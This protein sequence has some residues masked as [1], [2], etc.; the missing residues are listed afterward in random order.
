MKTIIVSLLFIVVSAYSQTPEWTTRYNF[1]SNFADVPL[2]IMT[3][4]SGNSYVI[5]VSQATATL[6]G[7]TL[8]KYNSS[9]T[10][11]WVENYFPL[12]V[13]TNQGSMANGMDID[14]QGNIYVSGEM[15]Y[16]PNPGDYDVLTLK[17]NS[18]G[19]K[20]W[21]RR[22]DGGG[23]I[24]DHG[25]DL[26]LSSDG[27]VYAS[28]FSV[29]LNNNEYV[30]AA[31][32]KMDPSD[33]SIIWANR[34][35]AGNDYNW[36]DPRRIA[37]DNNGNVYVM[38]KT[39]KNNTP[40][41]YGLIKVSS[42]GGL[43]W[44]ATYD[45][46][47]NST[48]AGN[49]IFVDASNNVY[50]TGN[51]I[52]SGT[53]ADIATIK[54]NSSGSQQWATR[55]NNSNNDIDVGNCI[56]IDASGNVYVCGLTGNYG[57][58]LIKYNSS[59]SIIWTHEF[60]DRG[61]PYFAHANSLVIDNNGN[62]Y[63]CAVTTQYGDGSPPDLLVYKVLSDGTQDWHYYYDFQ[64]LS[65]GAISG[66]L[67]QTIALDGS[68]NVYAI[69]VSNSTSSGEDFVTLKMSAEDDD[70]LT[71][72]NLKTNLYPNTPNPFNP[73]TIIAFDMPKDGFASLKIYN[74]IGQEVAVLINGNIMAGSY[75][76]VFNASALPSGIYFYKFVTDN[77]SEV[78]KMSL[79]K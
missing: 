50:I 52:G 39:N 30:D 29:N 32:I 33:G 24:K 21:E 37:K 19:T 49:S 25:R 46:P 74:A 26:V 38:L 40:S 76:K 31:V 2:K 28:S 27:Y 11:Q 58:I 18:S 20:L 47:V 8:V 48:D 70:K 12:N 4:A 36:N 55:Y 73:S 10:Q 5:G 62:F 64:N 13:T 57:A 78:R 61:G 17:Y 60:Y 51:S 1:N 34:Y 63:V 15:C 35:K 42:S 65:D 53:N 14:A 69:G 75:Q 66:G 9:G 6:T 59:G 77:F 16:G 23:N 72:S 68:N 45:G 67:S 7:Y 56:K 54:Y 43:T 41:D 71:N 79:I 3:D 44:Q 22:W